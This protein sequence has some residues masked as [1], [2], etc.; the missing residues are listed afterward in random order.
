MEQISGTQTHADRRHHRPAEDRR[1]V[2][3]AVVLGVA[4]AA[5]TLFIELQLIRTASWNGDSAGRRREI[6]LVRSKPRPRD[7]AVDLRV[8]TNLIDPSHPVDHVAD[9]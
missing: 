7:K 4:V 2:G 9:R 5:L 8:E 6:E 1:S 3:A